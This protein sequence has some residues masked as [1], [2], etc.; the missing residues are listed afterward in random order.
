MCMKSDSQLHIGKGRYQ[1]SL[2]GMFDYIFLN[3]KAP[4]RPIFTS[5]LP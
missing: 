5:L 4:S 3:M 1:R 2:S